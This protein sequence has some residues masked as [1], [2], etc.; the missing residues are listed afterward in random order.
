MVFVALQVTRFAYCDF[1]IET[2]L[3]LLVEFLPPAG[4]ADSSVLVFYGYFLADTEVLATV[5]DSRVDLNC[6]IMRC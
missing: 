1:N 2:G 4:A 3:P 5:H 6:N